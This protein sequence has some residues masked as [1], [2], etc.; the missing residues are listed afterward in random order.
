MKFSSREKF[1]F[2]MLIVTIIFA[3]ARIVACEI[4]AK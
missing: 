1:M 2:G 3:C 4:A